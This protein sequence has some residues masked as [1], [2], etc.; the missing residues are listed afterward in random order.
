[1]SDGMKSGS[2]FLF[3]SIVFSRTIY[4]MS[5]FVAAAV[6]PA[7][8]AAN[9][10]PLQTLGYFTSAFLIGAGL[11]QIPVGIYAARNGTRRPALLGLAVLTVTAGMSI[12]SGAVY[13]QLLLRFLTGLVRRSSLLRGS[14]WLLGR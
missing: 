12:V 9:G 1:M 3:V 10:H 8:A 6:F 7:M 11:F 14:Y 2:G 13:V 4:S 5:W